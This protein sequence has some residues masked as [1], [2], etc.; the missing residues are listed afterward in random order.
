MTDTSTTA[1]TA[2]LDGV[3]PGPWDERGP[4]WNQS[5]WSS[6]DNRVCFMAHSSGLNDDRDLKTARFI[7]AARDLVPALLAERDALAAELAQV[8]A[9]H[10]LTDLWKLSNELSWSPKTRDIAD[11]IR[12]ALTTKGDAK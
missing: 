4:T 3:T 8:R 5:I 11:R 7:A 1:I 6:T 10:D 9:Q 12:A 2:I